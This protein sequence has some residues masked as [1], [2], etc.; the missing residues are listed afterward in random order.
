VR[1]HVELRTTFIDST[2]SCTVS[3]RYLVVNAP[4]AYNILLG[5]PALDRVG[6]NASTRHIKM[7]LP[8]LEGALITIKSNQKAEKNAMRIA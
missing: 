2:A 4:L 1:G 7:K 5:R 3:I 6:V 8:S